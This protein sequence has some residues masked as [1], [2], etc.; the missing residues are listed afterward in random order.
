MEAAEE[1]EDEVL[2]FLKGAVS[3]GT[4]EGYKAEWKQ[5][6]DF[7]SSK[8][9][10]GEGGD[11]YLQ[12]SNDDRARSL[13]V[14][15]HIK[16]QY[17]EGKRDKKAHKGTAA[18]RYFFTVA[19]LAVA[20]LGS[21]GNPNHMIQ[22]ARRAA[23][24]NTDELRLAAQKRSSTVKLPVF[25]ELMNKL[26]EELWTS[27]G[28]DW[29]GRSK[30]GIDCKQVFMG[31]WWAYDLC[32]RVGEYTHSQATDKDHCIRANELIFVLVKPVTID[33]RTLGSVIGGSAHMAMVEFAN[34]EYCLVGATSH[35]GGSLVKRKFISKTTEEEDR[36]L[37]RLWQWI[38]CSGVRPED[39]LFT[40]YS[41]NP[42]RKSGER[43]TRKVLCRS[44]VAAA[45]KKA[46]DELGFDKDYFSTHSLRK[47]G[48]SD[49]SSAGVP[50]DQMNERGNYKEGSK[51]GR[52]VY[53]YSSRGHGAYSSRGLGGPPLNA[54][55][56]RVLMPEA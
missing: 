9:G 54:N 35:K 1:E 10:L 8:K 27:Q 33:G 44:A 50:E 43:V 53:D 17:D 40:R 14:C 51:V 13:L 7:I 15:R 21:V 19:G 31:I 20:F 11:P 6:C 18:I 34:V 52:A 38:K 36:S 22:A 25:S 42:K 49:M 4:R 55:D 56:I 28:W 41:S 2:E 48:R 26:E 46:A 12:K 39:E 37:F 5:W 32:A 47:A 45:I 3:E 24:S 16:A 23:G 29:T 30:K